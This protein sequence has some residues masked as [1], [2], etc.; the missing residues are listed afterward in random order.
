MILQRSALC[1]DGCVTDP[2]SCNK[3]GT[4]RLTYTYRMRGEKKVDN[5]VVEVQWCQC[6]GIAAL[7]RINFFKTPL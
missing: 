5:G 7:G 4:Q 3:S 2:A 6:V 1:N